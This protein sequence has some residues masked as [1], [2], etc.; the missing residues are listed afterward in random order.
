MYILSPSILA[1]DFG[2]LKQEVLRVEKAG[3]SYL[4]FD[5]MDGC[6]VPSISFGMPVLKAVRQCTDL[7]L[8]V[9]LMI[10]EPD[11]YLAEFQECGADL[12]TVHAEACRHLHRTIGAIHKLGLKAGVALNP[13]TSLSALDYIL[14]DLD[15]V[16]IMTVNPGFGGQKFIEGSLRKIRDLKDMRDRMGLSFDI[17][18]DG[19]IGPETIGRASQ[20][21]ANVFVAGTAVFTGDAAANVAALKRALGETK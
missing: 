4:H 13:A 12:I 17:E 3:V 14:P 10:E 9:H 2:C 11:R 20:A 5:V 18:V 7:T 1:A 6:F 15:M 16:L 8:D 21:G 19:G